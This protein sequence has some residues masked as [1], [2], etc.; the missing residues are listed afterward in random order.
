MPRKKRRVRVQ[1]TPKRSASKHK[2]ITP[3]GKWT[4]SFFFLSLKKF[5]FVIF[6][7]IV[8]VVLHNLFYAIFGFEEVVFFIIAVI[9][10]PLYLLI[11]FIYS[12]VKLV[13]MKL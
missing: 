3:T 13:E 9:I 10:I 5:V 1:K 11:A 6:L 8:F 2:D 4:H 7:W 12:L